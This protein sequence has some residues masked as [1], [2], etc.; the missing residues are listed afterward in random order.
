VWVWDG[1]IP[2]RVTMHNPLQANK[3][4]KQKANKQGKQNKTKHSK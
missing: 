3:K 4:R 2:V 1:K